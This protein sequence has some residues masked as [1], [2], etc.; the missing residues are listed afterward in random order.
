[1][2]VQT[3][4]GEMDVAS[5]DIHDVVT[6]GENCRVTATEWYRQGKLVRRDIWVNVLKAPEVGVTN[7]Q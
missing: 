5:L 7:G 4:E 3:A 1:M 6:Y 2:K